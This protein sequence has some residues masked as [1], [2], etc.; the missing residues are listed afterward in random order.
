M[1]PE[2]NQDGQGLPTPVTVNTPLGTDAQQGKSNRRVSL[3]S[4]PP[5]KPAPKKSTL[6]TAGFV[7][8][9]FHT[10]DVSVHRKIDNHS[11]F[12]HSGGCEISVNLVL[13]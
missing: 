8:E 2:E 1:T 4:L 12:F 3:L 10:P 9:R 13:T 6:S 7:F 11:R 5:L